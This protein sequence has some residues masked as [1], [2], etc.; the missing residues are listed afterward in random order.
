MSSAPSLRSD[1]PALR[2]VVV[3]T[4]GHIDHGKTELVKALTGVDCDRWAEEKDRGITID[5]GF[6]HLT[7]GD[8]Q[9]GFVDIPGHERFLHNALAGLG[10]IRIGLLVVAATEGVMPQ[11]REHLAICSLLDIPTVLVALTKVD[12]VEADLAEL[13]ELEIEDYLEGTRYAGAPIL[14]VSAISGEGVGELRRSLFDLASWHV[15]EEDSNDPVRFPVDRAFLLKGL[16]TVVTGTLVSGVVE[17]GDR[18][19]LLPGEET[20]RVRNVQVHGENRTYAS[21][22]ERTSLQ[23][24]GVGL[25]TMGRGLQMVTPGAFRAT[26]KLC[27]RFRLLDDSPVEIDEPVE[28]RFHVYSTEVMA[29][30]R[31]LRPKRIAPATEGIVEIRLREPVVVS[32]NDRFIVRRPTPATTLGGGSVLDPWWRYPGRRN[33]EGALE[34]LSGSTLEAVYYW[35]Q[36]SGARGLVLEELIPR[37]PPPKEQLPSLLSDLVASERLMEIADE[38]GQASRW[39]STA[40]FDRVVAQARRVLET[41]FSRHRLVAAMPKAQWVSQVLPRLPHRLIDHYLASL[42]RLDVLRVEGDTVTLPGRRVELTEAERRA[43]EGLRKA[44]EDGAL[45]PPDE[46]ALRTAIPQESPGTFDAAVQYLTDRGELVRLPNRALISA[47]AIEHLK[48]AL[49][50]DGLD[51]L[52]V[53]ALKGR[54]ELTRKWAIPLLEHLDSIG[55]TRRVGDVRLITR[56]D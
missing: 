51:R 15:I 16:G 25:E 12:L 6:A 7:E 4:L 44:M 31:P 37:V 40:T 2:R 30:L 35:I 26:T 43:V 48:A 52:T 18:L 38:P 42:E 39:V 45:S 17:P 23:V 10:G 29:M 22:G 1:A 34:A 49:R 8:L 50:E 36:S 56:S 9:V 28:V 21:A 54:F 11:T 19:A 46:E 47:S 55:F 32:R 41:F 13:G 3:G 53:Q 5:I 24:G 27:G 14:R 20:V 33:L